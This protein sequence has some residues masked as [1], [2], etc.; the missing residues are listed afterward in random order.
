MPACWNARWR[1]KATRNIF[2][3]PTTF[4]FL[5]TLLNGIRRRFYRISR[6]KRGRFPYKER[7]HTLL[8]PSWRA[9]R[10]EE[11]RL[12]APQADGEVS[13][14]TWKGPPDYNKSRLFLLRYNECIKEITWEKNRMEVRTDRKNNKNQ[15][16]KMASLSSNQKNESTNQSI[17]PMTIH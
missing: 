11:R 6:R 17:D 3:P 8:V 14:P 9:E 1:E 10:T 16:K 5:S 15:C 4:S 7:I 13:L 2:R 12:D